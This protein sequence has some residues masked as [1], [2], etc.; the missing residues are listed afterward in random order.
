MMKLPKKEE[1]EVYSPQ[2]KKRRTVA[3]FNMFCTWVLAYEAEQQEL[4]RK[5][6]SSPL[7]S[8][9]SSAGSYSSDSLDSMSSTMSSSS[10]NS[11]LIPKRRNDIREDGE[12][13]FDLITCYCNK[14]FA[15]RPMIECSECQTW[16]HLSCA[17]IRKSNIPDVFVCQRCRDAKHTIR[18]SGRVRGPKKRFIE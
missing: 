15:G 11:T 17:K 8:G 3:D 6:N 7:D 18:R 1:N 14:P 16:I 9:G 10:T 2:P 13:S 4:L 5:D 12:D